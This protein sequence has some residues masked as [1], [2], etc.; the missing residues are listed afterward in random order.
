MWSSEPIS[1][2]PT[3]PDAELLTKAIEAS[4]MS[5]RRFAVRVLIRDERTVRRWLSGDSPL[6]KPVRDFL[7]EYVA[8]NAPRERGK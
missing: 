6:P 1:G 4:G 7:K 5:A 8:D 2:S 3:L